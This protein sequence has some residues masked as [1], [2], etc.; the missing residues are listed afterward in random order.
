MTFSHV[1]E[2]ELDA[3]KQM[4]QLLHEEKDVLLEGN[5]TAVMAFV[6]RKQAMHRHLLQC[7][8]KR[9]LVMGSL[10]W[11]QVVQTDETLQPLVEEMK[12]VVQELQFLSQES[13]AW[14]QIA[15]H[16]KEKEIQLLSKWMGTQE[17]VYQK[18][19]NYETRPSGALIKRQF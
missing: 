13:E 17:D 2:T 18:Q 19:G 1:L 4:C 16:Y 3:L 11:N 5:P 9:H 7:E 10:T 14:N 12:R 15:K 8:E 6:E